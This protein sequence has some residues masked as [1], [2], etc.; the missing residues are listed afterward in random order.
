MAQP[1]L[2]HVRATPA[3]RPSTARP[4][5]PRVEIAGHASRA[6]VEFLLDAD[7]LDTTTL[8]LAAARADVVRIVHSA[9]L[10]TVAAVRALV[11]VLEDEV[12]AVGRDRHEVR[13]VLEVEAVVAADDA[14]AARRRQAVAYAEAFAALTWS[15]SATWLVGTPARLAADARA[16]AESTGVD[17]VAL[18]LVGESRRH[19]TALVG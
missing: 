2:A 15:P 12:R 19:A 3:R 13:L 14:D 5:V 9:A 8:A 4:D 17:T 16:L 10:P 11:T 6:D 18:A 1:V 7:A